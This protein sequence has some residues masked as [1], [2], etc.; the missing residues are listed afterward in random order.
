[1]QTGWIARCELSVQKGSVRATRG[2][3]LISDKLP[4][5]WRRDRSFAGDLVFYTLFYK[6]LYRGMI[7]P[8]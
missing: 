8:S 7:V 3:V 5:V 2:K 4:R 1:M 6:Y